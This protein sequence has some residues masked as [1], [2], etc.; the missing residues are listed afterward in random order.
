MSWIFTL[1][2][3]LLLLLL[4]LALEA[5]T[6]ISS[7]RGGESHKLWQLLKFLNMFLDRFPSPGK[8]CDNLSFATVSACEL[9]CLQRNTIA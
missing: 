3:P 2:T 7:K 9:R 1:G 6:Q 4:G 5:G 8:Q